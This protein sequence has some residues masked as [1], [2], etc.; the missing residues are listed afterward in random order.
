ML[1]LPISVV[2]VGVLLLALGDTALA[3]THHH[4]TSSE[5]LEDQ[6]E[7]FFATSNYCANN[8]GVCNKISAAEDGQG[9]TTG[10]KAI[11]AEQ[12][13]LNSGYCTNVNPQGCN[14]FVNYANGRGEG[15]TSDS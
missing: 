1:L 7:Q 10:A 11:Q 13:F 3:R 6:A 8:P 9:T 5:A 12:S 14:K 4:N 2:F 15:N